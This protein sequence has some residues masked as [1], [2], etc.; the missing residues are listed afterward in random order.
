MKRDENPKNLPPSP[1]ALP[2]IG[3][4]HLLKE[5]LH[6]TLHEMT[7]KYGKV[8]FLRFGTRKVLVVSSLPAIEECF[9]KNDIV[10]ANRPRLLAGQHLNYNFKAMGF[11][12][13]GDHWRNLRRLTTLEIFSTNRLAMFSGVRRE[14]VQ[15]LVKQ[16]F[17][18][19]SS[20]GKWTKV[21]LRPKL[22]ELAFNI[23]M[24]MIA[25][26]R[27][28]GKD[29]V[30]HKAKEFQNI[31]REVTELLSS[32]LNDFVPVLKWVDF[33]GVETRMIKLRKKMDGF[34][35]SLVDE[36]RSMA[37][38]TASSGSSNRTERKMTLID[39]M[40]SS[41]QTESNFFDDE[42]IKGVILVGSCHA[43]SHVQLHDCT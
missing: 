4:L 38:A 36:H 1:P 16:L 31:M 26:K 25:G 43:Y 24:K 6:R 35:Q 30:E 37:T 12:N 41:Q 40:L 29:A 17:Q 21:K 34:F 8:L 2:I 10:F 39:V 3:H 20:T 11:A 22:V 42:T 13:Y 5:P 28:Y 18:D 27:Y 7:E 19:Q 15:L 23:M 32:N 33:Q 14:E 9:T